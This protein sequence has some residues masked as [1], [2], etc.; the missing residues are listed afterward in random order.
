MIK[1]LKIYYDARMI[2]NSGI[3]TQIQNVLVRL[4][5]DPSVDCTILGD[6]DKLCKH[7]PSKKQKNII[8]WYPKIYSIKE[9][10]TFPKP[11]PDTLILSPHYNAPLRYLK[12]AVVVIHDLIHLH[13]RE[14][15]V[16]H[17]RMYTSF[18]L[19]RI[20]AQ[21]PGIIT[22]SKNTKDDLISH[23]PQADGKTFINY[24][25]LDHN[26]FKK[27]TSAAVQEFR[28][29][30]SLP[31]SFLLSVG[32]GKKHKNFDFVIRSLL[33]FWY[34]NSIDLPL[35]ISGTG[36]NLPEYL[37]KIFQKKNISRYIKVLPRLPEKEL[38]TMYAAATLLIMPSLY[39]G[40]GFPVV[41]AMACGTPVLS[42]I[43]T[44][45][46]EVGGK[47]AIYF[48]PYN[49]LDFTDRLFEIINNK[50]KIG[51][52]SKRGIEQSKKFNWDIHYKKLM[53]ILSGINLEKSN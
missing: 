13:S 32:I 24:N 53:E 29:K 26:L 36:G 23:F 46:P 28:K 33:P 10:L 39:E 20:T 49:P 35:V 11:P 15:E 19:S 4:V 22:V 43:A 7:L 42:S 14:F 47:A 6:P 3:G 51:V 38:P 2:E 27:P 41:E 44:S 17:Y 16:P 12:Q 45:L 5:S 8:S 34:E 37:V 21:S 25:G 18:M 40:F 31:D 1:P 9:Q 30:Y 50:N 52:I 48:D